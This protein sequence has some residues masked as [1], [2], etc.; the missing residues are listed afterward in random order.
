MI[1]APAVCDGRRILRLFCHKPPVV[2][3]E[4]ELYFLFHESVPVAVEI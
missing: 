2:Q 1:N 3:Y 4:K